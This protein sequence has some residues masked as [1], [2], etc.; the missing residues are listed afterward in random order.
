[1]WFYRGILYRTS[2]FFALLSGHQAIAQNIT[3]RG[4]APAFKGQVISLIAAQDFITFTPHLESQ[5]TVDLDGRFE[6][7]MQSKYTMPVSIKIGKV[8]GDLYVQ[9]DF[10]Y[11]VTFPE[12]DAS[13]LRKNE[14]E[15][16]VNI[17]I[18]GADSTE[19]NALIFD[20]QR[21]Y[22]RIFSAPDDRFISRAHLFKLADSLQLACNK[23]YAT[24]ANDYFRN[25][26]TYQVALVNASISRGEKLLISA[27]VLNK[28]ILY[29]HYGYMQFFNSCFKGYLSALA[30][31]QRGES[32]YHIINTNA[33]YESLFDFLRRD[34]LIQGDSLRELIL[35]R[36]LWDFFYSAEFSPD[37][38]KAVTS[39]L[40]TR[41][42]NEEHQRITS[43]MLARFSNLQEGSEAPGFSA[44]GRDSKPVTL[45]ALK[46]RWTY[47]NFFSTSSL[48]SMK[49]MPKIAELRKKYG[50]KMNFVSVCVDDS[51]KTYQKYLRANPAQNWGIWFDGNKTADGK[52]KEKYGIAGGEGYF[53]ISPGMLFAMSPALSPSAGIEKRFNVLFKVR[54]KNTKTGIR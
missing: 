37:A 39:Q 36:N 7:N 20:Y 43:A 42:G 8:R 15:V 6:L 21:L 16:P 31:Q 34:P 54:K 48:N 51:L 28:P 19:L 2:V 29:H 41:T 45:S 47:L 30:S 12:P 5:D 25:F 4:I 11:G 40:N 24:V 1:M 9:P 52:A 17:G 14:A 46:G 26:I 49:E 50:D 38:V 13:A 35:I 44:I 27:Y 10:V 23:R 53:L 22:N 18:I 32:M 33:S 3:V